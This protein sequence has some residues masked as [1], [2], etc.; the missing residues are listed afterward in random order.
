MPTYQA[1]CRECGKEFEYV[2]KIK[3]CMSVPPCDCGG[4]ADK[5][6]LSAPVGYVMGR[7]DSF[8][9]PVDGSVIRTSRELK[10]HNVRNNVVSVADGYDEKRVLAGD[11]KKTETLSSKERVKDI[12]ESV[13]ALNQGYKPDRGAD[14]V[15]EIDD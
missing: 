8:V 13:K 7:F 14:Y 15:P 5:V 9:S 4:G 1:R 12:V 11:Y 3:D 2:S 10:E 6:I